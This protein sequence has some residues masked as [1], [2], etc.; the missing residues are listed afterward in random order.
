MNL[1]LNQI[2]WSLYPLHNEVVGP[3]YRVSYVTPTVLDGL[4]PYQ[5]QMIS[6]ILKGVSCTMAFNLDLYLLGMNFD[7]MAFIDY[8]DLTVCCLQKGH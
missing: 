1:N 5:A 8:M 3:I 2:G 7:Y 6:N 4:F